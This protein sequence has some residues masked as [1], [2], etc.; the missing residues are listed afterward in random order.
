MKA[1]ELHPTPSTVMG[2]LEFLALN[3]GHSVQV[4][5]FGFAA[6]MGEPWYNNL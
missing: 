3:M 1:Q 2:A 4:T 5:S 6:S